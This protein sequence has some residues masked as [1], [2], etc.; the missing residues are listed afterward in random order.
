MPK[1]GLW[2]IPLVKTVKNKNMETFILDKPHTELL[3]N[4]PPP[5]KAI[6]NVYIMKTQEEIIR[7]LHTA[8]GFPTKLT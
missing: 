4:R 5:R 8:A 1:I 6:N 3:Q 7:Y 2:Y